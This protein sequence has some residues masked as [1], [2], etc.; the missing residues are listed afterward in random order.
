MKFYSHK[1]I[2][3]SQILSAMAIQPLLFKCVS[4]PFFLRFASYVFLQHKS[5]GVR[6]LSAGVFP[7]LQ[8]PSLSA[9]LAGMDGDWPV[10]TEPWETFYGKGGILP[11][12]V[13]SGIRLRVYKCGT[14]E[15][16]FLNGLLGEHS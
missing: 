2:P 14:E 1:V 15:G 10:H 13:K 9:L 11:C 4:K 5:K 16:N 12:F 3:S 7:G 8:S 6:V